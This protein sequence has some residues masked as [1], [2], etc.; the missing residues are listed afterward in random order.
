MSNLS[1]ELVNAENTRTICANLIR[2][3]K[4]SSFKG[5]V[6]YQVAQSIDF[7][8]YVHQQNDIAVKELKKRLA[9]GDEPAQE[10]KPTAAPEI[11]EEPQ[12]AEESAA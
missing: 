8:T 12:A 9:K 3:L 1:Q 11:A 7:I 4:T 2:L 6:S 5:D 10:L